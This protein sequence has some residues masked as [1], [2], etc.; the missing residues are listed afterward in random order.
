MFFLT[1]KDVSKLRHRFSKSKIN[2]FRKSLYDI[3]A[4]KN[5]SAAEIKEIEKNLYEL[6]ESLFKLEKYHDYDADIKCYGIRD[7]KN[8]FD[9]YY[10]PIKTKSVFNGNYI[11]YKSEG[12]KDKNFLA[13]RI[14]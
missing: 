1:K 9:H 8:L 12:D 14:S 7:V 4:R 11:E 2:K 5:L 6:E 3:K 13:R 10:K